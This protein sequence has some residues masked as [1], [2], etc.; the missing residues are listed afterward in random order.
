MNLDDLG[1]RIGSG[2]DGLDEVL[3]GGFIKDRAYL[4]RGGPGTGKTMLGLHF[5]AA[6]ARQGERCLFI[7][8]AEPEKQLRQNGSALGLDLERVSFLDLSPTPEFF[9]ESG[10]YDIFSPA[11]VDLEPITRR[12]VGEI[13]ALR[14]QRVFL[15]AMTQ[16]RYLAAEPFH[17]FKQ[18]LSFLRFL[19]GQGATVLF[20]SEGSPTA[21]DEDLQFMADGVITLA[22]TPQGRSLNVAKFRG[23]GFR[24]GWHALRLG[25][26]GMTIFP[27]LVP[28]QPRDEIAGEIQSLGVP[29]LDELLH[30]GIERGTVTIISGPSGVGKT[31][32]CLQL[33]KEVAARRGHGIVYTFDE[34]VEMILRRCDAISLPVRSLVGQGTLQLQ[35]IE[36]LRFSPAEFYRQVVRDIENQGARTVM[37]DSIA[38]FRL[39]LS[40]D[41]LVSDLHALCRDLRNR[42][43]TV[44]LVD[45]VESITGD[46]QAT[47]T[48]L[49]YL[50]DNIVFLRYLEVRG[51]LRKAI[52]VL[53]KRLGDFEKTL[54]EIEITADGIKVGKPLTDLRGILTGTPEW[55]HESGV[56]PQ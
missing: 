20:T 39:S 4:V 45:E 35:Q 25:D 17:F 33:L 26:T 6:G 5:L 44:L 28:D 14:P 10:S 53:K 16:F 22:A 34:S 9:A 12:I 54:R 32:L 37:I 8:L 48:G 30:G 15:D 27:R 49:G 55:R 2:I 41:D 23:S 43:M 21:P 19:V 36:P 13:E 42:G 11:E 51:E 29:G 52:G 38:G 56:T 47:E 40:G 7:T 24:D 18:V 46:F 1:L 50:A 3:C 31:T